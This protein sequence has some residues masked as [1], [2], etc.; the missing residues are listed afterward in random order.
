MGYKCSSHERILSVY[1]NLLEGIPLNIREAVDYYNVS[2]KTIKRDIEDIRAFLAEQ[3]I[4]GITCKEVIYDRGKDSYCL[5]SNSKLTSQELYSMCKVLIE[6][7]AFSKKE[8]MP[9]IDKIVDCCSYDKDNEHIRN[10]IANEKFHY[11]VCNI[12][13][14]VY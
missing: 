14:G 7:R 1:N 13:W 3:S 5:K 8:F 9:L 4:Q 2:T 6:S 10:M 11:T 12:S